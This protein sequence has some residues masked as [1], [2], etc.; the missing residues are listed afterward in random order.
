MLE[1]LVGAVLLIF[2]LLTVSMTIDNDRLAFA[3]TCL[4]IQPLQEAFE[5]SQ[6]VFS[7]KAID[8]ETTNEMYPRVVAT[9]DIHTIWK[10]NITK[11]PLVLT[12]GTGGA[13]CGYVF[14]ENEEYLVYAYGEEGELGATSCSRTTPLERAEADLVF[15]GLGDS[16]FSGDMAT[17][18]GSFVVFPYMII[19][20]VVAAGAV[21]GTIIFMK[22]RK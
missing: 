9:F 13:D 17:F 18:T 6:V 20:A 14:A 2:S 7:G 8:L 21:I 4:G 1:R 11:G 22:K 15:L 19:G 5:G 16:N 10:G 3:C 12:T